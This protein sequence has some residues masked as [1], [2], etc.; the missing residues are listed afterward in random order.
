L[1]ED[2][3]AHGIADRNLLPGVGAQLA[4]KHADRI[5][6]LLQGPVIPSL[7]GREAK[8][9]R[10]AGR[11]MLPCAGGERHDRRLQF[12]FGGRRRQ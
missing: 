8:L 9:D 5:G 7:D 4:A 2:G 11:R 6:A 12:A 3:L 1:R 10:I